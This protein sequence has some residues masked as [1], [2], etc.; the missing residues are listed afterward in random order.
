MAK[1]NLNELRE[2]RKYFSRNATKYEIVSIIGGAVLAYGAFMCG[3]STF[4]KNMA[5]ELI[6]AEMNSPLDGVK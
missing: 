3:S 6:N 2:S 1:S 5:D 4:G